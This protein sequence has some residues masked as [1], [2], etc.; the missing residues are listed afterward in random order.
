M[1]SLSVEGISSH[2]DRYGANK[3]YHIKRNRRYKIKDESLRLDTDDILIP[4][5]QYY[6]LNRNF[7]NQYQSGHR[8][9]KEDKFDDSDTNFRI[10]ARAGQQAIDFKH[11]NLHGDMKF[12]IHNNK[13]KDDVIMNIGIYLY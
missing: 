12:R 13:G 9:R 10:R 4:G 6:H 1:D 7:G 2:N 11:P 5:K 8:L 3:Y